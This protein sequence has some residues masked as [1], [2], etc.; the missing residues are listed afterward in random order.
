LQLPRL[1]PDSGEDPLRV[2]AT[3]SI[4]GDVV[5]QVGG[6]AIELTTLMSAGQDPHSYQPSASD[7]TTVADADVIFV[8]GWN[9]EEGLAGD[10]ANVA[11][12]TPLVPVAAG[13]EPIVRGADSAE[14]E[15]H[16]AEEHDHEDVAIDPHTWLDPQQVVQ[17]VRNIETALS[18]LDPE[19]EATYA[20]NAQS[21]SQ[22]L[23]A[24]IAYYDEQVAR[25][26]PE[27]RKLVTN[28][29]AL[30]YFARAYDFEVVGTVVPGASTLAEPSASEV[31]DLVQ[32]MEQ[33]NVCTI[34]AETTANSQLAETVAAELAGCEQVQV[35]SLYTGSLGVSGGGADS[36]IEMMRT[37]IDLIVQ[38]LTS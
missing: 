12:E 2:I 25:I 23:E 8:H 5:A 18:A 38:G 15:E 26:P 33:A 22:E 4:I 14:L 11:G 32:K 1:E 20:A 3:T 6:D 24:L 29:D 16:E 31:V 35:L 30:A 19:H 37:N 9:L 13:V 36:Y 28:H 34:F 27:R 10:L 21:Y 7:L 17:W